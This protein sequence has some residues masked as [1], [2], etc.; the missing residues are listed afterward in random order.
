MSKEDKYTHNSMN[1]NDTAPISF[2]RSK[3]KYGIKLLAKGM[4]LISISICAGVIASKVII[5]KKIEDLGLDKLN[6][7]DITVEDQNI[8]YVYLS[9]IIAKVGPSLVTISD[10]VN[11]LD[12]NSFFDQNT[13]GVIVDAEGYIATSYSSI[14]DFKNIYVKLSSLA[15]KPQ[16]AKL[17]G[18]YKE[19]DIAVIKI[20]GD[21]YPTCNFE[22]NNRVREGDR[23]VSLGNAIGDDY[24]GF[25]SSGIVNSTSL[26]LDISNNKRQENIFKSIQNNTI[27]NEQ[28][29]G[30][31][32]CNL[33]GEIIGIN[34]VDFS[35]KH[36][37]YG[38]SVVV[39]GA[40][41]ESIIRSIIDTGNA[42]KMDLGFIG[43]STSSSGEKGINGIYVEWVY[44]ESTVANAG[45]KP[46]DIIVELDDESIKSIDDI[47]RIIKNH[48]IGDT[49]KCRILRRG[50]SMDIILTLVKYKMVL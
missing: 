23:V 4:F 3:K 24:I 14:E 25:I 35:K 42:E 31:P 34:S 7:K 48:N 19:L 43:G 50:E 28:N 46:T 18:S 41:L 40:E 17:V 26:T 6:R 49:I 9:E 22:G 32:L 21:N 16:V 10:E 5:D 8:N 45:I 12:S 1:K 38:L 30:G 39:G 33:D 2:K 36:S 44:P 47:N 37:K 27:V 13:T 20:E 29:N 15:A 11:R